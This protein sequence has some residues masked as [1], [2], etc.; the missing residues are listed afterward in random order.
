MA[1]RVGGAGG[2]VA[3]TA[4]TDF[5]VAATFGAEA[6][7]WVGDRTALNTSFGALVAL[8]TLTNR[9]ATPAASDGATIAGR[10]P[11]IRRPWR[12]GCSIQK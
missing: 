1:G 10:Q 8:G 4:G 5:D 3:D 2:T 6:M 7:A 12:I 11:V 9:I